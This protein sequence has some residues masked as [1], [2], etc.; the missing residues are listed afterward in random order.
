M[1]VEESPSF[2]ASGAFAALA[3]TPNKGICKG[4]AP[5]PMEASK[6]GRPSCAAAIN[7]S[8]TA[9]S[10]A[11]KCPCGAAEFAKPQI[12]PGSSTGRVVQGGGVSGVECEE[13]HHPTSGCHRGCRVRDAMQCRGHSWRNMRACVWGIRRV[14]VSKEG[15]Y[16]MY[17]HI[18]PPALQKMTA[19]GGE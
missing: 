6:I 16:T 11:S 13:R 18:P 4:A 15:G 10:A 9:N 2:A 8:A 17:T 19:L 3:L 14:C 5:S 12:W 7:W 1:S